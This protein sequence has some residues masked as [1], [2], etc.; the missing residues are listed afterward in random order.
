MRRI[1]GGPNFFLGMQDG[2]EYQRNAQA[3]RRIVAVD[4][5]SA[6]GAADGARR[7]HGC[8]GRGGPPD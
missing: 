6:A 4:D 5:L 3:M 2:P 1:T 7:C 8:A